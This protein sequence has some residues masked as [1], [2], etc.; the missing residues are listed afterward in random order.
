MPLND[1]F[2]FYAF[3]QGRDYCSGDK[4]STSEQM[5]SGLGLIGG[6]ATFWKTVGASVGIVTRAKKVAKNAKIVVDSAVKKGISGKTLREVFS[7]KKFKNKFPAHDILPPIQI[8]SP[9]QITKGT[10]SKKLNYVVLPD[11]SL[12]LGRISK[13]PGGGHIDLAS[14]KNIIAAGEVKIIGGKIKHIDNSSGHYLPSGEDAKR[15]AEYAFKMN[16][17]DIVGKYIEKIWNGSKW[18][19]KN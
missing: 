4:L 19:P 17:I 1:L 15:A 14:G 16:G 3:T 9:S 7:G 12:K 2:D 5:I 11:G 6:N 8:F 18:V 10:F 13:T